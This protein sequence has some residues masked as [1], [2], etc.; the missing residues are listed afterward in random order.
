METMYSFGM[1]RQAVLTNSNPLVKKAYDI[2][3]Y[4]K[5]VALKYNQTAIKREIAKHIGQDKENIILSSLNEMFP[6]YTAIPS[7]RLKQGL[8]KIYDDLEIQL[9]AK[10]TD[11][12][13][14]YTLKRCYRSFNGKNVQCYILVRENMVSSES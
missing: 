1:F 6:Q 5:V 8:Q 10:A 12:Q 2:L 9:T 13:R 4:D 7:N 3:G 11:L 14:W